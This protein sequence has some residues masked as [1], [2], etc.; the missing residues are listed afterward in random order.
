MYMYIFFRGGY[1]LYVHVHVHVP[2]YIY[3]LYICLSGSW[4]FVVQNWYTFTVHVIFKFTSH[5]LVLVA[6]QME[7]SS[8]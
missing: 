1:S 4:D 2:M 8:S 7:L 3:M 6:S 5:C